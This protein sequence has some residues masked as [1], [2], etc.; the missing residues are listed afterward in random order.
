MTATAAGHDTTRTTTTDRTRADDDAH[1]VTR[2]AARRALALCRLLLAGVFLW[3][4][5]DKTFGLGYAT[6]AER[7]W[8]SGSSPTAGYLGSI[9]SPLAA[10]F[11]TLSGPAVDW[12]FMLGMLGT[13]L[14]LLLGIGLR[15]AAVAGGLLMLSLWASV[16]PFAA[17]SQN[18][19]VDQH[20]LYAALLVA[21]ALTRAGDTWGLGRAWAASPVPGSAGWLR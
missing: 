2:P 4:V 17:G 20:L 6:P 12:L 21:L 10:G 18:P 9:E 11:A 8:V 13:G 14:A 19:V 3:P 7:A 5:A 1:V 16:W 15:V